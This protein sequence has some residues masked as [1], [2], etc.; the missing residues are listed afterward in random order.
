MNN[1]NMTIFEF[2]EK[3]RSILAVNSLPSV[4]SVYQQMKEQAYNVLVY[5]MTDLV[6]RDWNILNIVSH[7]DFVWS[8]AES[9]TYLYCRNFYT[10]TE[11][12]K[13]CLQWLDATANVPGQKFF[14]GNIDEHS[15]IGVSQ[16]D[17]TKILESWL[18]TVN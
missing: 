3:N 11:D 8:V 7:G 15:L 4:E 6:E 9:G 16:E 13:F 18:P 10:S 14:Q 5:Y 17:A 2:L 1:R 12:I